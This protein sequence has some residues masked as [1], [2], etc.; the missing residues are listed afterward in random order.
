MDSINRMAIGLVDEAIDFAEELPIG[1]QDPTERPF[2][3][4]KQL[5]VLFYGD[6][7]PRQ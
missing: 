5:Y 7:S 6:R 1:P 4:V 3:I 2:A